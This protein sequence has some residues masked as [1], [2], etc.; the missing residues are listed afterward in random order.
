MLKKFIVLLAV[1]LIPFF[2]FGTDVID[3]N[4]WTYKDIK[5]LIDAGVIT[6]ELNKDTITRD[7]VVEY[8]NNG[9]E[10]ILYAAETPKPK[11][12]KGSSESDLSSQ[13]DKLYELV[14]AY[15]TDM[16]KT[17]KKLDDILNTIGDLRV[18]KAEL[19]KRQDKLL[20]ALGMRIN[21]E[22]SG[23][24]T[25]FLLYGGPYVPSQRYR[26]ITQ[27]IDLR[28][29]LNA[30]K[31][32]YAEATYR[33]ENFFGGFW[34]SYD[35]YGLKRFFLQGNFPISF[36]FGDF[37]G[38]LTPFTLWA[39]DDE[40][41]FE[42][43]IF[44]DR[45]DMN[46]KEL[47]LLD[48]SWPLTGGKVQT[49]VEL[50]DTVDLDIQVI[51]ARLQEAHN[52]SSKPSILKYYNPATDLY[53]YDTIAPYDA[54]GIYNHDQ[55]MIGGRLAS[56][57]AL[58]KILKD[59]LGEGY[60]INFGLNYNEIVD[61]KDTGNYSKPVLHNYV[62]SVDGE[63]SALKGIVK[64][65]GEYAMSYYNPDREKDTYTPGSALK[66]QA[67][68]SLF[69]TKLTGGFLSV[70]RNF[71]AFA[72]QTRIYHEDENF[73]YLTQNSTWNIQV[74]PPQYLIGGH[75]YPFT[76]Y[77][78]HIFVSYN[79]TFGRAAGPGWLMPYPVYENN[80]LPY[81]DASPNRQGFFGKLS[82]SYLEEMLNP[83]VG[84]KYLYEP[85]GAVLRTITSIEG[86]LKV[87]IWQ[88]SLYG[89]YKMENTVGD[90]EKEVSFDSS[91]IDVGAE[92]YIVP[93]KL[94]LH[95]GM[96]NTAFK[97]EEYFLGDGV[98]GRQKAD[99]SIFALG[100]GLDYK[101]A[102]PATIGIAFSNTTIAD[103]LT[104]ANN[105]GA[106]ELDAYVSI[107]F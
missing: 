6:K 95:L 34:G 73:L 42:A 30:S 38:K 51:G 94:T 107:N 14:K 87:N 72:A 98:L 70:E 21:G 19:E 39:V 5:S 48:N 22:S 92:Y 99:K 46:K 103:N 16:M 53:I 102:K 56:D 43:K 105:F 41:P 10:N 106:Q 82:G 68:V 69:D 25:D 12:S 64:L 90:T 65:S 44:R 57:F 96:K 29:S 47:Y 67:E 76:K 79:N 24:M 77:N 86:G 2:I 74:N 20:N 100:G 88:V 26:P 66:A 1:L 71:I 54:N 93:K 91:I 40:H 15:M 83:F 9:V 18:K 101:I 33:L 13:I 45:R 78:P 85:E 104:S 7:E 60:E 11:S 58:N 3:S 36:V 97:G 4:H 28:F 84:F 59:A 32:V 35:A 27:Y 52:G 75:T 55:Y 49:I 31:Y 17:D 8:I 63:I 81:G 89:G 23:Y 62:G 37:Q 61:V 80:A 50:F